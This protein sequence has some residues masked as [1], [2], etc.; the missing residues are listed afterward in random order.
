VSAGDKSQSPSLSSRSQQNLVHSIVSSALSSD[1]KPE[2]KEPTSKSGK[3]FNY[4]S[5]GRQYQVFYIVVLLVRLFIG[6]MLLLLL[7][8]VCSQHMAFGI[9]FL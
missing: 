6:S 8:C 2:P 7:L 9:Q 3:R 4:A 1:D 5:T